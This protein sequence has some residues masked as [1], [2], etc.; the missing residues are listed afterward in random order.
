ML[1]ATGKVTKL[2]DRPNSEITVTANG[3]NVVLT[4]KPDY[5]FVDIFD[6]I[7]FDRSTPHGSMVVLKRNGHEAEY[8]E[9]LENGDELNVYWA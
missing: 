8:T 4:G 5:V 2:E 3:E 1:E 6:H 7:D 9:L